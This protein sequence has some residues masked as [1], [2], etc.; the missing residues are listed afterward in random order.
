MIDAPGIIHFY[1]CSLDNNPP[2][3]VLELAHCSLHTA[4]YN[5][6]GSLASPI[7]L[8]GMDVKM[9]A[10]L[11]IAMALDYLHSLGIIHRDI[12]TMNMLVCDGG[13][14]KVWW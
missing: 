4:L 11:D 9:A 3:L 14:I 5:K 13:R 12:K 10:L 6:D 2:L 8:H 7:S 1:G